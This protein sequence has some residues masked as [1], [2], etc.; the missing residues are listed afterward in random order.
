MSKI[1]TLIIIILIQSCHSS[2]KFIKLD[3]NNQVWLKEEANHTKR[4]VKTIKRIGKNEFKQHETM[5]YGIV[6]K[7]TDENK[8]GLYILFPFCAHGKDFFYIKDNNKILTL[9]KYNLESTS[10]LLERNNQISKKMKHDIL[11]YLEKEG[12]KH[13]HK[14]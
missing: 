11:I 8:N 13:S 4:Q 1:K 5:I 9:D 3:K 6:D 7:I 14:Q 10:N 12:K 2:N